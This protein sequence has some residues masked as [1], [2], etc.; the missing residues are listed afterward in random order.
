MILIQWLEEKF[1]GYLAEWEW[2]VNEWKGF[3]DLDAEKV[4]VGGSSNHR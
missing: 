4:S 1:L 2:S 3:T